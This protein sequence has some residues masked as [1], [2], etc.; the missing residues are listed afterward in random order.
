MLAQSDAELQ[1]K[2]A[3][4]AVILGMS[5]RAAAAGAVKFRTMLE[6]TTPRDLSMLLAT[7]GNERAEQ[8]LKIVGGE[9]H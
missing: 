7:L 6:N 5:N 8:I 9:T 4:I 2:F 3:E 1:Q